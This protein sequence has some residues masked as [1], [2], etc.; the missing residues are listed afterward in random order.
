MAEA[1]RCVDKKGGEIA[2]EKIDDKAYRDMI[3]KQGKFK[4]YSKNVDE[5]P[6]C[7]NAVVIK[8]RHGNRG[9]YYHQFLQ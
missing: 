9:T 7:I 3:Y 5:N 4:Q 6:E 2:V 8:N 1:N